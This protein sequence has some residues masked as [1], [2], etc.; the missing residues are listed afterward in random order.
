[1]WNYLQLRG[2]FQ[3][4]NPRVSVPVLSLSAVSISAHFSSCMTVEGFVLQP[5]GAAMAHTELPQGRFRQSWKQA[6]D[7]Q[8]PQ[9]SNPRLW[10]GKEKT[11]LVPCVIPSHSVAARP[12]KRFMTLP[13]FSV[14]YF[15]SLEFAF[16]EF[17]NC[18]SVSIWF[19]L[20]DFFR[21]RRNQDPSVPVVLAIYVWIPLVLV[22]CCYCSWIN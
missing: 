22:F 4:Q 17:I 11:T 6:L 20:F 15:V 5:W 13:F 10:E 3:G 21:R 19:S 12:D 14:K 16:L 18:V 7:V 1:M 8:Q 2:W 9:V